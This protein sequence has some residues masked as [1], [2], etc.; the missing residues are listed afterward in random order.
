M[1][2]FGL[3]PISNYDAGAYQ[4]RTQRSAEWVKDM[5][6]AI[7]A[8]DLKEARR[9]LASY[10]RATQALPATS[11][12][13]ASRQDGFQ[14]L[15]QGFQAS[16]PF[17]SAAATASGGSPEP[18]SGSLGQSLAAIGS[19]V[20]TFLQ[21]MLSG[22]ISGVKAAAAA[23]QSDVA[24]GLTS[25]QSGLFGGRCDDSTSS[26][27]ANS[28][29]VSADGAMDVDAISSPGASD[30]AAPTDAATVGSPA[31]NGSASGGLSWPFSF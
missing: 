5:E 6:A 24:S 21:D 23:L 15:L 30:G 28:A 8:G 26:I 7:H 27:E 4:T 9:A 3:T 1:S 11:D 25:L 22:D 2:V 29:S 18:S 17:P 16:G 20:M 19:D 14:S 10:Q 13:S 12:A 31:T